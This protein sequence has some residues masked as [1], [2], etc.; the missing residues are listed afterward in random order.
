M[1]SHAK[2]VNFGIVYGM[3]EY[4]LAGDLGIS[5]K[6]AREYIAGYFDK[7]QGVREYMNSIIEKSRESGY[8]ETMFARRRTI[9]ELGSSNFMLRAAGERMARNTP[10]QGSAAD[11]I[12]LAM[13]EV[14][15]RLEEEGL[16]SSLILQVHDELIIEAY[17]DETQK[18][19]EILKTS[20][21][22]AAKLSVPL[23]A[24]AKCGKSWYDAK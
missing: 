4:S 20:M 10:I 1:R 19:M 24:E 8:V 17:R 23:V 7:Y 16:K 2:T 3:G 21:E 22:N 12:K 18:V 15:R 13:V 9:P 11:I 6:E 14:Y 5:V